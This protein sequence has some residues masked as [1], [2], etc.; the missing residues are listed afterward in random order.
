[1]LKN[2]KAGWIAALLYT[3]SIYTSIIA[4]LFILPD[5]PQLLFFTL[6]I[7]I[8]LSWVVKPHIFTF[9]DW[10]LLGLFIGLATLSKIHGLYLWVGFG[11]YIIFNQVE[12]LK[13]KKIFISLYLLLYYVL[14]LLFIGIIKMI[15]SLIV[16][17]QKE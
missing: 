4:G 6:S 12:N 2:E 3:L 1:M 15:L 9:F 14:C 10:I 8:M 5:S 11:L 13:R 17:T 7:Y 16:F